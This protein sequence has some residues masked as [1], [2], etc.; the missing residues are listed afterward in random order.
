MET[1]RDVE[2]ADAMSRKRPILLLAATLIFLF[3]QFFTRPLSAESPKRAALMWAINALLLM[4]MLVTRL[5]GGLLNRKE[6]RDLINDEVAREHHRS[7]IVAGFWVAMLSAMCLFFL[8]VGRTFTARD[9]AYVIVTA[10]VGFAILTFCFL[11]LR[12]HRDA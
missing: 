10:S 11:E 7:A 6:V 12:A 5:Q 3:V 8:D 2:K 1:R 9:G 4:A